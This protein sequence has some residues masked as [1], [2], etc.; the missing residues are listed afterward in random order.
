MHH[1]A[2][3]AYRDRNWKVVSSTKWSQ[4]QQDSPSSH[5]QRLTMKILVHIRSKKHINATAKKKYDKPRM[6]STFVTGF[7]KLGTT[8]GGGTSAGIC[9]SISGGIALRAETF[10][11]VRPILCLSK[12]KI[13]DDRSEMLGQC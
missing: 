10:G 12:S 5:C 11:I 8:P 4:T 7:V 3:K 1:G 9:A 6:R 13:E 2:C